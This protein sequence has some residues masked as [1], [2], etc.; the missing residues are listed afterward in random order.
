[1]STPLVL[2]VFVV[3]V[4][5]GLGGGKQQTSSLISSWGFGIGFVAN[6]VFLLLHINTFLFQPHAKKSI[7]LIII[8]LTLANF[9]TVSLSGIP[10]IV[11]FFG[12]RNFM[13]DFGCKAVTLSHRV[14]RG[15]SLCCTS[16][17]SL[18]QAIKIAP[19]NSRWAWLKPRISSFV[20]PAITLFLITNFLMYIQMALSM[21]DP[22]NVTNLG[23][24]YNLKY[25][26]GGDPKKLPAAVMF[27]GDVLCVFLMISASV[28][29]V[30]LLFMHRKRM[31]HVHSTSLCPRPSRETKA[32]HTILALVSCFVFFY[33]TSCCFTL[34]VCYH[35]NR[36][37]LESIARFISCCYAVICPCLMI[38]NNTRE[39]FLKSTF[40]KKTNKNKKSSP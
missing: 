26:V 14:C 23:Q 25:C 15:L 7:D 1:M 22:Y 39:S 34:Y 32:T 40:G 29:M 24:V 10:E 9:M 17:L 19:S 33:W 35:R 16:F 2:V 31:Q 8:H 30:K 4:C 27:V 36:Q 18:F 5:R 13:G 28:Y 21:R 3:L 6:T 12:I 11:Y 38:R 20:F 37:G